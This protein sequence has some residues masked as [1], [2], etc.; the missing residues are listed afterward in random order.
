MTELVEPQI[1]AATLSALSLNSLFN[2]LGGAE[3]PVVDP[4]H[5]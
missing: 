4:A 1:P 3:R 2:I 5:T